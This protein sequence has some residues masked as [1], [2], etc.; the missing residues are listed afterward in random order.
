LEVR[1]LLAEMNVLLAHQM[2]GNPGPP[3]SSQFHGRADRPLPA[4]S[5]GQR[6]RVILNE[7]NKTAHTGIIRNIVWHHNDQQYNYYIEE[8]VKRI[9]KRYFDVDLEALPSEG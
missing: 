6:V 8:N 9:S 1:Q 4:F 2:L 5:L 3:L 7:R